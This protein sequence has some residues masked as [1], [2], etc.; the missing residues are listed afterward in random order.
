MSEL[1]TMDAWLARIGSREALEERV[2]ERLAGKINARVPG[3][4]GFRNFVRSMLLTRPH[5]LTCK[6]AKC[7]P[8]PVEEQPTLLP[9][10]EG[11]TK[12][13]R[14]KWDTRCPTCQGGG[15]ILWKG[16]RRVCPQ[17]GE[18]ES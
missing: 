10:T 1:E 12:K 2:A 4:Y 17:C 13:P 8:I 6:C 7:V 5:G 11:P 3:P 16:E 18:G 15:T 14:R 9:G